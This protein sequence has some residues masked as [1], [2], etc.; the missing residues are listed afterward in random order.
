MSYTCLDEV[1]ERCLGRLRELEG[2]LTSGDRP[3]LVLGLIPLKN[4]TASV[5]LLPADIG[6][7]VRHL[8][9]DV[10]DRLTSILVNYAP[11]ASSVCKIVA[12]VV[13]AGL[14]VRA[15]GDVRHPAAMALPRALAQTLEPVWASGNARLRRRGTLLCRAADFLGFS[16]GQLGAVLRGRWTSDLPINEPDQ[17]VARFI[18]LVGEVRVLG[19]GLVGKNPL[20]V[21]SFE[22]VS[23]ESAYHSPALG[24]YI[25]LHVKNNAP[26][27]WAV[28][29][30]TVPVQVPA[31]EV[32]LSSPEHPR[33]Q[34]LRYLRVDLGD[35]EDVVVCPELVSHLSSRVA[36]R[37]RTPEL[38]AL[39]R[40][41]AL[42]WCRARGVEDSFE[43]LLLPGSVALAFRGSAPEKVAS[44]FV[45]TTSPG[46]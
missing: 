23:G 7:H 32:V 27:G 31:H 14:L 38:L 26:V 30:L 33:H 20:P 39:L 18:A 37:A 21:G 10:A 24:W 12:V 1:L 5:Q 25:R 46:I 16:R 40:G 17:V 41:K 4:Q 43:S 19:G 2:V 35:G 8:V 28:E 29:G 9:G 36:F 42:E 13:A 22:H 34:P 45:G 44:R 3:N 15:F 6:S 11:T